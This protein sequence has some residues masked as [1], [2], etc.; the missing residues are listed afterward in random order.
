MTS[1]YVISNKL[2]EALIM[3]GNNFGS[4]IKHFNMQR[5]RMD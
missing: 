5:N 2:A 3:H 4:G 1:Q